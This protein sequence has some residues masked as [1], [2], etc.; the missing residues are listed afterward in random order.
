MSATLREPYP[1]NRGVAPFRAEF[2][3][4][5]DADTYADVL[6]REAADLAKIRPTVDRIM[7]RDTNGGD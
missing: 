2:D 4:E 7:R 6:E 1:V 3:V 5:W